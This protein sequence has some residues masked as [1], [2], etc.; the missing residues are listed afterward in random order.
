M[1]DQENGLLVEPGNL[2]QLVAALHRLAE[3]PMLRR[4]Q[5]ARAHATIRAAHDAEVNTMRLTRLLT[6]MVDA[7][8]HNSTVYE[9]GSA[10]RLR[11]H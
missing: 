3:D 2:E 11:V 8:R 7:T 6:D 5:G 1:H 4:M 9:P 10:D